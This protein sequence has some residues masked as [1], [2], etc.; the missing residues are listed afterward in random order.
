VW[1]TRIGKSRRQPKL[2]LDIAL[3]FCQNGF[4]SKGHPKEGAEKMAQPTVHNPTN[5]DPQ[6]YDVLDYLD[7]KR[8]AY[9]G[10]GSEAHDAEVKLWEAD[11]VQ[12]FGADWRSKNVRKCVHCGHNPLRWLTVVKHL[13][14][15]DVVVF[16]ADCTKRLDFA[17]QK[18]FKLAQLQARD[19]ANKVRIKVWNQ[20]EAFLKANPV[21]AAAIADYA[22]SNT[23]VKDVVAK[24]GLYGS[25]SERQVAA[26][27]AAIA[28]DTQK[29]AQP[30]V[31]EVKGPAPEGRQTVTGVLV[32]VKLVEGAYGTARKGLLK[33][34]N[35][36]KV[37]LTV[38]SKSGAER[39]DTLTVAATFTVSQ[40]D[41]SF[42]FGS[43]PSLVSV[44]KAE[45][46][47]VGA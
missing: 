45:A 16:G 14:T 5:F 6:Q 3:G 11:F 15:G 41:K 21:F 1:S 34:A 18:T 46:A 13:L 39:G 25:L 42:A 36:S 20:R 43:R 31:E 4:V 12:Y 9:F 26:V 27:V 33:L 37:W 47:Q 35:N 17:D 44:V 2:L 22:G 29:A 10:Q 28:R 7:G 40:D 32:S 23:F 24:L 30:V 19:A 38:P 8:P